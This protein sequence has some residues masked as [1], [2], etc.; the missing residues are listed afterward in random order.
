M[1]GMHL[2]LS[3]PLDRL[4][5]AMAAPRRFV[6]LVATVLAICSSC[7]AF[8]PALLGSANSALAGRPSPVSE[9]PV[10][11]HMGDHSAGFRRDSIARNLASDAVVG[12]DA[13][14]S[15]KGDD[16]VDADESIDTSMDPRL[17]RVRLSRAAGIEWGTDL[18]FSFVYIR[19]M[20]PAGAA[21]LSGELEVGDQ[22]CELRPV[23][24]QGADEKAAPVPL[25]GAP[26]DMVMNAFA[27]LSNDVREIDLVFF[28]GTK[29]ELKSL[30]SGG[31]QA[32]SGYNY[33][34][35][36]AGQGIG[37]GAG[38]HNPRPHRLQREGG[39]HRRGDQCVPVR[40]PVDEL[41][42]EAALRDLH[43]K[44]GGGGL[45]H[46]PKVHGRGEHPQGEPRKLPVELRHL[47]VRGRDSRDF[48]SHQ[49]RPVD[50]LV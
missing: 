24:G 10:R 29:D 28:R 18:S 27:T 42:G 5:P 13:G 37:T 34:N 23:L 8:S 43:R 2:T 39:P 45:G 26:F 11:T 19:T 25:V 22:L 41:Q 30:A 15:D 21:D 3:L 14:A 1:R 44:H 49:S 6:L 47:R 32:R 17:F 33:H 48:P 16:N 4:R 31:G 40:H 20:E 36:G 35:G 50:A 9:V 12:G 46:Q 7:R 38:A